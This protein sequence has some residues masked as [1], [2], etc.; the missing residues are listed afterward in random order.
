MKEIPE[1][2]LAISLEDCKRCKH[3]DVSKN[4]CNEFGEQVS[5]Q[6][7]FDCGAFEENKQKGLS[8]F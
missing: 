2:I 4:W 5:T 8:E 3:F 6:D 7:K 1:G